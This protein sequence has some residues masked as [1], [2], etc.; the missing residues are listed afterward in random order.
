V[1]EFLLETS[2]AGHLSGALCDALTGRSDGQE[3]LERLERDNLFEV[4]A[5]IAAGKSNRQVDPKVQ[6]SQAKNVWHNA[7]VRSMLYTM[8]APFRRRRAL[9]RF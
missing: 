4:L 6:W 1:R 2:I 8:T 9:R 3:M 5:L 7:G